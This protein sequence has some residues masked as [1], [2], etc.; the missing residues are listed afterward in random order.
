MKCRE[1]ASDGIESQELVSRPISIPTPFYISVGRSGLVLACCGVRRTLSSYREL[2]V[3]T[4][5]GFGNGW[6]L[7]QGG[8]VTNGE[9]SSG[10]TL[11]YPFT[12]INPS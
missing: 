1:R 3:E 10:L 4:K 6:G 7:A 8:S 5:G 2:D 9:T 11:V 12:S